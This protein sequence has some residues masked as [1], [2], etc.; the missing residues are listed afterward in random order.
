[1][2]DMGLSIA[3]SGLAA[4]AAEI[5]T[6]SNNLSNIDTPGYAAEQVNLS[7]DAANGAYGAGQGVLIG[8]ITNLTDA[9]FAA[10][11]VAA[12]G[13]SSGTNQ[14]S[15]VMSSIESIFP[16]PSSNGI[17]S[18]LTSL[19]S[20]ISTLASN[21]NQVGAQQAAVSAAQSVASSISSSF[22]QLNQLSS[23]LESQVGTGANDGGLL[24]EANTLLGQVA[25]LNAGIV[26]GRSG[27]QN[28]NALSDQV[29]SDVNQLA[30]LLGVNAVTQSN[31]TTTVLLNGVQLV[32]GTVAQSLGVSGSGATTNL[33]VTT[34]DGVVVSAGGSIGAN[35]TAVNTTIPDYMQQLDGVADSLATNLN[36][37]QGSGM[38]S[39]GD[40]GAT[41]AGAYP[42]TIAPPIFVDNGSTNTYTTS[43]GT[44]N[45][46]ATIQVSAALLASPSMIATA[47]APGP[48]NS[49]TLGT[50]T[51]DGSNAQAMAA[52]ASL[53]T[54]PDATYQTLIGALGN[55]ASSASA[56]STIASAQAQ[57]AAN[58]LSSISG[59]NENNEEVA[60]MAAQNAFQAT[61][62]V[63]NALSASFQSLL[64]AV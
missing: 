32:S 34:S 48:G 63:V 17:A 59:V 42:G 60:L 4:D 51:L 7:P 54:G 29:T 25:T 6:I 33:A 62:Q 31:G 39:A 16:E 1:M 50:A 56:F 2:S 10:A 23:S 11:N 49:N 40:P 20:S 3:G 5:D 43:S 37:L 44:F 13:T 12:Q 53:P 47:A 15:Q 61:S 27:G 19:W 58:N 8:S 24:S 45:S 57:T 35:L 18:Q 52:L 26:A 30:N 46:A 38:D 9:V 36:A 21:P 41:I 64:S 14:F 22:A 55:Q 28:P